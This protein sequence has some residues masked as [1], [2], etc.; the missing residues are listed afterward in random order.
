[1]YYIVYQRKY[2][3]NILKYNKIQVA[4]D[5]QHIIIRLD[6][7]GAFKRKCGDYKILRQSFQT[8]MNN[9]RIIW[10]KYKSPPIL[11]TTRK[12][13]HNLVCVQPNI[14]SPYEAFEKSK[15]LNNAA[16]FKSIQNVVLSLWQLKETKSLRLINELRRNM[17]NQQL[18]KHEVIQQLK[19]MIQHSHPRFQL[20]WISVKLFV[21]YVL[22][23]II[24]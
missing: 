16:H 9:C 5:G 2:I 3:H 22:Y 14:Y 17:I 10:D 19:W 15:Y 24:N 4:Q 11:H 21:F 1:M 20:H 23:I 13:L 12:G 7:K 18:S 6:Q 8:I